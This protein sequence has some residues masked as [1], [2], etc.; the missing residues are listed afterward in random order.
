MIN[1]AITIWFIVLVV[2][3]GKHLFSVGDWGKQPRKY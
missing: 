1:V 2:L 3:L